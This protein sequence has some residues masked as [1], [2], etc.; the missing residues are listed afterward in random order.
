MTEVTYPTRVLRPWFSFRVPAF[1][2][3]HKQ[4]EKG[5]EGE[6][7]TSYLCKN[8]VEKTEHLCRESGT[9]FG[10]TGDRFLERRA[11]G[12]GQS[13]PLVNDQKP[14]LSW[15]QNLNQALRELFGISA[16]GGVYLTGVDFITLP[17]AFVA[18][19]VIGVGISVRRG[20]DHMGP[21]A[22]GFGTLLCG[23]TLAVPPYVRHGR[24]GSPSAPRAT[25]RQRCRRYRYG[26]QQRIAARPRGV[27]K[28]R[29]AGCV[30][31]RRWPVPRISWRPPRGVHVW[32]QLSESASERVYFFRLCS[33]AEIRILVG[34][35]GRVGPNYDKLL[36]Q[37]RCC[38]P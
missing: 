30:D 29:L 22:C 10:S 26:N 18:G 21:A 5:G 27:R 23:L 3:V 24:L 15:D 8:C 38:L 33:P 37:G 35:G 17:M 2:F 1:A 31:D 25:A 4:L 9:V 28:T 34:V 19:A 12:K 6:R 32:R 36:E 13:K 7:G 20:D 16:T 14:S 11:M